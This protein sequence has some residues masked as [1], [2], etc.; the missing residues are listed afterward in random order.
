MS[1]HGAHRGSSADPPAAD[2]FTGQVAGQ[3]PDRFAGQIANLRP[4]EHPELRAGDAERDRV[5][6]VLGEAMAAGYLTM[7]EFG[8][9]SDR[10]VRARTVGELQQ[11]QS[12]L[13]VDRIRTSV[14]QAAAGSNDSDDERNAAAARRGLWAHLSSYLGTMAL[15]VGIWLVVGLTAD[16][17][18]FWPIW[19]MLGWGIGVASHA[20]PVLS[21]GR[22]GS[23]SAPSQPAVP[24]ER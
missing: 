15:V 9:R 14:H 22:L 10:L 13:P 24:S 23:P 21:V 18:Y 5:G 12:D 8:E 4:V 3:V 7:E 6:A 20:L 16:A 1:C 19:P 17:W 2:R 11:L